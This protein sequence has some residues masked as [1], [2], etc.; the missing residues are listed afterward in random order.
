MLQC[1]SRCPNA[2]EPPAVFECIECGSPIREGEYVYILGGEHF[3][4]ECVE[5]SREEA[6][7]PYDFDRR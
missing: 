3:C 2:P 5:N 1:D 4:E 6:E 7:L